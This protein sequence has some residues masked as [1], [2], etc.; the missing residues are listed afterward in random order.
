MTKIPRDISGA[1]ALRAFKKAGFE[2]DHQTGSHVIL[3]KTQASQ[4]KRLVVPMHSR[5]KSGLLKG[6]IE[7]AGLTVEQFKK[8]L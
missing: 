5:I 6:L 3:Y 4:V 2:I 7:D 8:F 1:R